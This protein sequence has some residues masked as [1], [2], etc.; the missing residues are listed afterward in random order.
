MEDRALASGS[1]RLKVGS[2]AYLAER[3]W[4]TY[5]TSL[6]LF[7]HLASA[8]IRRGCNAQ[9]TEQVLNRCELRLVSLPF[10]LDLLSPRMVMLHLGGQK[11]LGDTIPVLKRPAI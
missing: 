8:R 10:I 7:P 9:S 2:L 11:A 3:L 5:L 6:S 4:A 1:P